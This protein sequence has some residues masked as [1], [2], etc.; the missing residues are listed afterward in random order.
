MNIYFK[1]RLK[2][3]EVH[4]FARKLEVVDMKKLVRSI[5]VTEEKLLLSNGKILNYEDR[6]RCYKVKFDF[7]DMNAINWAFGIPE[8]SLNKI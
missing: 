7:E 2:K 1:N 5:E 8:K 4:Q 6:A 3:K